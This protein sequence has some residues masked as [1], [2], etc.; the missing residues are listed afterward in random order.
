[1]ANRLLI[2]DD[3]ADFT[4]F[5]A[6]VAKSADYEV[7]EINDSTM[8]EGAIHSWSPSHVVVDLNM[9]TIDGL[10]ALRMLA[11][12]DKA[13][14]IVICSGGARDFLDSVNRLGGRLGLVMSGVVQ[15]PVRPSML[16]E[17][18]EGIASDRELHKSSADAFDTTFLEEVR[19]TMGREW[20]PTG[21]QT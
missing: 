21:S 17:F 20:W 6:T 16:K 12:Q 18:L 8:F 10:Q 4:D 14:K 15:K 5:F 3:D 11:R 2:V 19:S 7:L 1:M 13:A 9:P